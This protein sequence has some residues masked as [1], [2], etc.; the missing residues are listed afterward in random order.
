MLRP[1]RLRNTARPTLNGMSDQ[2]QP[3]RASDAERE[4]V[5]GRLNEATA[6]GRLSLA[7][8]SERAGRAYAA[9]TRAELVPL[10]ADL[11][12][13]GTA[14]A[15][16]GS[17]DVVAAAGV[18]AVPATMGAGDP[19]RSSVQAVP[20]GAI[21]RGGRWQLDPVTRMKV[22]VGPVKLDLSGAE[23][24]APEVDLHVQTVCGSVKVWVPGGVRVRVDGTTK[25]GTR[26]IEENS[27]HGPGPLV[28]LHIDTTIGTVKVFRV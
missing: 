17:G 21:K 8:F 11:P 3:L 14:V 5:V 15:V 28:R 26:T 12:E 25:V 6:Q 24:T 27:A 16:T 1:T 18:G 23:I 9:T 13:S 7:E 10:L 20:V 22:T 2:Q 4:A 19:G